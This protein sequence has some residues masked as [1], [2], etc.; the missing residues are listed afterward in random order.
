M[1]KSIF[2]LA[3]LLFIM[4]AGPLSLFAQTTDQIILGNCRECASVCEKTLNYCTNKRGRY[5]EALTTN[6]LKDCITACKTASEY[7]ARGSNYAQ[8]ALSTCMK[9]CSECAKVCDSFKGDKDMKACADECRKTAANCQKIA[10]KPGG[11]F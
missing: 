5:G 7:L 1:N 2:I 8:A 4:C 3:T 11:N 10:S 6:A 9:A